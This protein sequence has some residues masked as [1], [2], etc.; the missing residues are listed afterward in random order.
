MGML[1]KRFLLPAITGLALSTTLAA[2]E[3]GSAELVEKSDEMQEENLDL[4]KISESFGFLIGKNLD[5]LGFEF[6][7][8]RVVKGIQDCAAGKEPPMSETECVQA[9]SMVQERAFQKLAKENLEV[10]DDF[11][12]TNKKDSNIVQLEEGKLQYRVEKEGAGE[13]VQAH[14]SPLIR[15]TGKFLDGKI[16]GSSKE[17]ELISL[18]DTIAGFSKGIVGMKE[19]EKRTLFIHPTLG[20][21]M[22]GYLPPNSLLTF[23]IEV[24]KANAPKKDEEALS[25]N[26]DILEGETTEIAEPDLKA[27][28]EVMQ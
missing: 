6:D 25:K 28:E 2:H 15:Y 19:G 27:T 11:M 26:I 8:E 13:V 1:L 5:S 7:M 14:F 22:Q 3:H 20:Y 18:D 21:G 16:F 17:D 23:E 4:G 12:E 9:I 24:V 10:A